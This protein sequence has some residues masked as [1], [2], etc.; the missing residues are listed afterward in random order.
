[1]SNDKRP[2]KRKSEKPIT[3]E[4]EGEIT[5]ELKRNFNNRLAIALIKQYGEAGARKILEEL[6][7]DN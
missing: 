6:E 2:P 4:I 5:E 1:M 7:K 3:G